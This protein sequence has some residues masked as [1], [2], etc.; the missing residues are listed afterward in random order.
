MLK[1]VLALVR[2]SDENALAEWMQ[3]FLPGACFLIR[4]RLGKADVERE[5]RSVLETALAAT[6]ADVSVTAEQLPGMVRQL[7]YQQFPA[8]TSPAECTD[9]TRVKAAKRAL[10]KLSPVERDALRRCYVLGEAP[11]A[12]LSGLK[13]TIDEFRDIQT[14][15]RAEFSAGESKEA[16]VA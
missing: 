1:R 6:Q 3:A 16:S 11:E 14:R 12:F 8:E 7:I 4:R 10:S 2:A 15:A 13:L 5:A 9:A